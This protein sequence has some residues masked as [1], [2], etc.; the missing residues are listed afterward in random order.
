MSEVRKWLQGM[1]LGQCAD[2]FEANDIALD[3][4]A[5]CQRHE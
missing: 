5:T 4:L 1:G 2:V 3:L